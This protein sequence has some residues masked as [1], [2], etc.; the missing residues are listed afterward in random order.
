MH[1]LVTQ[2]AVDLYNDLRKVEQ[3]AAPL[4]ARFPA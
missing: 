1:V 3:V 2:D 4:A